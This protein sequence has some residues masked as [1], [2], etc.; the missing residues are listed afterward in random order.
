MKPSKLFGTALLRCVAT[1]GLW[2]CAGSKL[3]ADGFHG[4]AMTTKSLD[5][6]LASLKAQIPEAVASMERGEMRAMTLEELKKKRRRRRC[7]R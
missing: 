2:L 6:Y 1:G 3:W 4:A 7:R 5:D